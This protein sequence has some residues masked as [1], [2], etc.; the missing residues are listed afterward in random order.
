M[1]IEEMLAKNA[2]EIGADLDRVREWHQKSRGNCK[3]CGAL[4]RHGLAIQ[5]TYT[6]GEPD[7]PG[8]HNDPNAIVTLSP[9]GP[10]KL[11][12]CLKCPQCGWSVTKQENEK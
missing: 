5:Q 2:A 8:D 12:T 1:N 3:K 9:G 10:G 4:M 7:F 6:A 11:I